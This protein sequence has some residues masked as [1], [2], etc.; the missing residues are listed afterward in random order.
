MSP[1]TRAI[2]W[3]Q[4]RS[5]VNFGFRRGGLGSLVTGLFLLIWYGI[6]V[7]SAWALAKAAADP[8]VLRA[9]LAGELSAG[10][11]LVVL[12]WQ[13]V[14][15]IMASSGMSLD[16]SRLMIYPVPHAHLFRIELILRMT[17]SVEMLVV[18][19]GLFAG[20]MSNPS[21]PKWAPLFLIP[22]LI[23]NVLLSAGLRDLMT[24]MLARRGIREVLVFVMVLATVIPQAVMMSRSSGRVFTVLRKG[25]GAFWPWSATA[26]LITGNMDI[27]A[28]AT[29]CAAIALA[30]WFAR[31]Q[32]ERSLRFDSAAA[33]STTA[34]E[35]ASRLEWLYRIPERLMRDPLG[36]LVSKEIRFLSRAPRFRLLFLMGCS[37]GLLIW[38]PL[39][40]RTGAPGGVRS[41]YLTIVTAYALMLLG[42]ALFWNQFG[43]DRS[44]AQTYFVAP[45]RFTTV[46]FAKNVAAV[47]FIT[48]EVAFVM[49]ACAL[50]RF[51]VTGR[52]AGEAAGV[53]A[54]LTVMLLGVGNLMSVRYAKP[55]DPSKSW[56]NSAGRSQAWLLILYPVLSLPILLAYGARYA[57]DTDLGF[58]AV[59]ALDLLMAGAFYWVALESAAAT[60][61]ERRE[62]LVQLLSNA[63]TPVAG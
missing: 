1:Q 28:V 45:V 48:M 54:V 37:F 27:V 21:V 6:W 15:V 2:L 38:L 12:Y 23:F 52:E 49:A 62:E 26:K 63:Q 53:T 22:F 20:L 46:L 44:A 41:N 61:I 42:E 3:A 40:M 47:L 56:R 51:P 55:V 17:T 34:A 19:L 4:W 39:L 30:A 35:R 25:S 59:I 7:V 50:L 36:V 43:M 18:I 29:L 5:L 8:G 58:W 24:R 32:F 31:T 10:L 60:A 16:L 13:I 57:F 33:S 11:L 9:G 14:P